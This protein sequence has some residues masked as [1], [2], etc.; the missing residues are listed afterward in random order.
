MPLVDNT[1]DDRPD[2]DEPGYFAEVD[3]SGKEKWPRGDEKVWKDGL[4]APDKG[5]HPQ[6]CFARDQG[7]TRC[8]SVI[9]R[10]RYTRRSLNHKI[11]R[12][13]C[14]DYLVPSGLQPRQPR[15]VSGR[16]VGRQGQH[17]GTLNRFASQ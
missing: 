10:P 16:R 13:P 15:R 2:I 1:F 14:P 11:G 5:K 4:R 17:V 8:L 7:R 3:E 9:D 6:A 12:E